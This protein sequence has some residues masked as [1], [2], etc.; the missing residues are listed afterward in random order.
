MPMPSPKK[1]C[2]CARSAW[3]C[4][5]TEAIIIKILSVFIVRIRR[6]RT[7]GNKKDPQK[8]VFWVYSLKYKKLVKTNKFAGCFIHT[9]RGFLPTYPGRLTAQ[10]VI[11]WRILRYNFLSFPYKYFHNSFLIFKCSFVPDFTAITEEIHMMIER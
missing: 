11:L 3:I 4:F 10:L 8:R 6:T 9:D 1:P 7:Y 5:E 2:W